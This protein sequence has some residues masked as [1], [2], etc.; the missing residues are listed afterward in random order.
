[1]KGHGIRGFTLIEML[2]V[3]AVIG[4]L[5]GLLLPALLDARKTARLT[6]CA[7]NLRQMGIG[8][9]IYL[10]ENMYMYPPREVNSNRYGQ[11]E[12]MDLIRPRMGLGT[13]D[14]GIRLLDE[15]HGPN[16]HKY[17]QF[18]CPENSQVAGAGRRFDY[19]YNCNIMNLNHNTV[20]SDMIVVHDGKRYAPPAV[21]GPGANPGIHSD[22]FDN[23]LFS[24]GHVESSNSF[25]KKAAD[26]S[27]WL[28]Q[29]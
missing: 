3:I 15:Y 10:A 8:F 21:T 23:Y 28:S 29:Y 14:D 4:M 25:Y 24:D 26:E 18:D 16:W 27:P 13:L 19:A 9:D 22:R 17:K 20:K 1:M 2:V 6:A 11:K 12:W 7:N 5:A